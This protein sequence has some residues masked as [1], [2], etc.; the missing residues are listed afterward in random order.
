MCCKYQNKC[1]I[2][3]LGRGKETEYPSRTHADN[4]T[5]VGNCTALCQTYVNI[6][7]IRDGQ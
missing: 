1:A 3:A 7:T 2:F 5:M 4:W 6:P